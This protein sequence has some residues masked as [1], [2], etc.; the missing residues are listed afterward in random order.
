MRVKSV[1]HVPLGNTGAERGAPS[2]VVFVEC[3]P[4]Q[5]TTRGTCEG[6]S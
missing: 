1:E 3:G 6:V 2:M 4:W 5:C